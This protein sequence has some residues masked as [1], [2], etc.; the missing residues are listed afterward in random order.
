MLRQAEAALIAQIRQA[1]DP[2]QFSKIT[3]AGSRLSRQQAVAEA[4]GH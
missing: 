4:T 1:Q 3:A 2:N